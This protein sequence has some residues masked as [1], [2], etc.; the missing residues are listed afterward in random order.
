MNPDSIEVMLGGMPMRVPI[1]KD[2][3]TT[4]LI[5]DTINAEFQSVANQGGK[6]NTQIF[7][8]QTAYQMAGRMLILQDEIQRV[9]AAWE[10]RLGKLTAEI[11]R[12]RQDVEAS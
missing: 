12:L 6:F 10:E 2:H 9:E 5:V 1:C 3:E 4:Q 11:E 7:A 8:L